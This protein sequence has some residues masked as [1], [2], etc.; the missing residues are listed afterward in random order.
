MRIAFFSPLPPARSGIAD[1]SEALLSQLRSFANV[2]TFEQSADP[3]SHDIA[4]YQ[5]G[6]NPFHTFAYETA[7]KHPGIVVL[8]EAN[9][10]HLLAELTIKRGDWDAY[11][12]EVEID[13]GPEALA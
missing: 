13:G 9:L 7:M 6:N 3:S 11:L 10:H 4:I 5:L 1:Y 2:E 8:H 12:R